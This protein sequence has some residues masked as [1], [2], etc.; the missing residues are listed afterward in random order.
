MS[1]GCSYKSLVW[2]PPSCPWRATPCAGRER[3]PGD[4]CRAAAGSQDGGRPGW[5]G[6]RG[7]G[8]RVVLSE[9][10]P[11]GRVHRTCARLPV[12]TPLRGLLVIPV[13]LARRS[14]LDSPGPRCGPSGLR[15]R[16][17]TCWGAEQWGH[18]PASAVPEFQVWPP[19]VSLRPALPLAGAAR[20]CRFGHRP[21]SVGTARAQDS[22]LPHL[23]PGSWWE[24]NLLTRL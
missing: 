10:Q 16:S 23:A 24:Q 22:R 3:G 9:V 20:L 19:L 12:G 8:A 11:L 2:L 17:V 1:S 5:L 13:R 21:P 14:C 7:A 15:G 4:R 6:L 18:H